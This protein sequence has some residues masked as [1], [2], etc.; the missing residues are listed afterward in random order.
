[1]LLNP[2]AFPLP[3]RPSACNP[4]WKSAL[5]WLSPVEARIQD[6]LDTPVK[7]CKYKLIRQPCGTGEC[8]IQPTIEEVPFTRIP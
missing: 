8:E 4:R 2:A 7:C 5:G 6:K 1:M 3:I